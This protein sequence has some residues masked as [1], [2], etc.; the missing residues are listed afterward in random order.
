MFVIISGEIA[1]IPTFKHAY[2]YPNEETL[3]SFVI[4][5]LIAIVFV[6]L[7]TPLS[8]ASLAIP[9]DL[10]IGNAIIAMIIYLRRNKLRLSI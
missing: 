9:I 4:A 2:N 8:F 3:A 1:A 7:A 10:V 6:V 5:S